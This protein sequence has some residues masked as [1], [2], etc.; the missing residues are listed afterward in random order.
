M[1]YKGPIVVIF[2]VA[3]VLAAVILSVVVIADHEERENGLDGKYFYIANGTF[4]D[5]TIEYTTLMGY[6]DIGKSN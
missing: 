5:D 4:E 3:V 1:E 6:M 2:V